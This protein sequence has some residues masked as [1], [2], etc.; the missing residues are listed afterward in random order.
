MCAKSVVAA[1][2]AVAVLAL[3]ARALAFDTGPHQEITASALEAE[4]FRNDAVGVV[5]VN[6]WFTDLYHDLSAKK[7]GYSGQAGFLYRLV[8]GAVSAEDWPDSVVAAATRMHFDNWPGVGPEAQMAQLGTTAGITGEWNRLRRAVWTLVQEAR[9]QDDPEKLLAV[10]GISLHPLQDFYTHTDWVE[11][12]AGHG[13]TG[14]D[15]PG[16]QERGF[17]SSPTWFDIPPEEREKVTIYGDNTPGHDRWHGLWNAD[18]NQTMVNGVNKDWPGRPLYMAAATSAYFATRQW[19][20]AVRSWVNDDAFWREAQRYQANQRQ[21]DHDLSGRY[22]LMVYSGHWQGQGEPTGGQSSGPGGNLLDLREA[23]KAYFQPRENISNLPH[24]KT[25]YRDRWEKLI[26]RVAERVPSGQLGPVPSSQPLQRSMRLVVLRILSYRGE[27]LGDPGPDQADVY[28]NVGIDGQ[29]MTS[30]VIH[31]EDGFA[32]PKPNAPFTWF[33]AVPAEPNEEEPVE[34]IEVEVDTA[35]TR[36]A[37]TDDDV[38][39]RLGR[40]GQDNFRFQ[41]DKNFTNDFEQGDR[42]TYSVPIDDAV[43]N[44]MTVGDISRVQLEK[45]PDGVAGG[46]KLGGMTLR[47]NGKPF[48]EDQDINRWLEDNNRIWQAPD[49]KPRDSRGSKIPVWINLREDDSLYGSDDEGDINRFDNR[50][51]VGIGYP[52]GTLVRRAST[53]GGKA[54][55]GRQGYGG[56]EASL[57]YRLETIVPELIGESGSTPPPPAEGPLPDLTVRSFN[58]NHVTIANLGE[59]AAGPFRLRVAF[60]TIQFPG[61]AP[62]AMMTRPLVL[63]CGG[64]YYATV[65]DLD[66]I[67]ETDE[68]NNSAIIEP[69]IC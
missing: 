37:G 55:G 49:F 5:Q 40:R 25:V 24:D 47:V 20:E 50:D 27:G 39:L 4:G 31:G 65:D 7:I 45:T 2:A 8:A 60:G 3:P 22:E 18:N 34:S 15:G 26:E 52:L 13:V 36:W 32:F 6:N 9:E 58:S 63:D 43:R 14:T 12:R 30:A 38:F 51:L 53:T 29:R 56:D 10:L 62:G 54:L 21:L 23:V 69:G 42:D 19:I 68:T 57:T 46:W 44:G 11:P 48:Y 17:G 61:L 16:W 41:L 35:D 33:K 1:L 28:A 64:T 59:G 67:D 66:Q